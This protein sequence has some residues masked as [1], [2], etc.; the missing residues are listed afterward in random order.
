VTSALRVALIWHDE[1]M[2]DVVLEKP[3]AITLGSEGKSTFVVPEIG[4]PAKFA[5]V[6][7]YDP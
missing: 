7:P 5:I 2:S 1:V 3:R 6:L 4:L